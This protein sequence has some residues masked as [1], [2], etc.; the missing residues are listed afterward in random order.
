M[1]AFFS[2]PI[3]VVISVLPDGMDPDDLLGKED[4]AAR[5]QEAVAAGRDALQ[6]KFDRFRAGLDGVESLSGRQKLLEAFLRELCDLGFATLQGVRKRLI[7]TQ[8]SDL[9]GV[10]PS[11]L[12]AAMPRRPARGA[13]SMT[14]TSGSDAMI[15]P[16]TGVESELLDGGATATVSRARRLAERDLL[17]LLLYDPA[18]SAATFSVENDADTIAVADA[19]GPEHFLGVS[20]G[21]IA[22]IIL[23]WLREER[24]FTMQELLAALPEG[25]H[26]RHPRADVVFRSATALRR[27]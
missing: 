7:L 5:F 14:R 10:S 12:Q 8:L 16:T 1:E 25:H 9:L 17:A 18:S 4:G 15:E 19:F 21:A 6:F 3:D 11:D 26:G 23:P 24:N 13:S 20:T 22:A 2:A 27:R